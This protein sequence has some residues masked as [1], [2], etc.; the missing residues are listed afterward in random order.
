MRERRNYRRV[1]GDLEWLFVLQID[2]GENRT[3]TETKDISSYGIRCK[4]DEYCAKDS[5]VELVLLLPL[6]E[7]GLIFE[8]IECRGRTVRC[9]LFIDKYQREVYDTAFEFLELTDKHYKKLSRYIGYVEH[10]KL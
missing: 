8:K 4:V 6:T 3:I 1:R 2:N 9:E 5:I 10:I 7:K